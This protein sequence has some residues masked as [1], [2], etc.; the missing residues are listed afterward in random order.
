MPKGYV[1]SLT[2]AT[3]AFWC[4]GYDP[5]SEAE[6]EFFTVGAWLCVIEDKQ[7]SQKMWFCRSHRFWKQYM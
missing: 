5:T 4:R 3:S 6:S 2:W 7:V 1:A